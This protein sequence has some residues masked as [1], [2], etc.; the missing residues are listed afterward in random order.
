MTNGKQD[1]KGEQP[2]CL[3]LCAMRAGPQ[4]DLQLR[5]HPV[6]AQVPARLTLGTCCSAHSP[7]VVWDIL[8]QACTWN[9]PPG[10]FPWLGHGCN[11]PSRCQW[12]QQA[13]APQQPRNGE[14]LSL[15]CAVVRLGRSAGWGME[16]ISTCDIFSLTA[17]C[18]DACPHGSGVQLGPQGC[19]PSREML[20][21][22]KSQ[23]PVGVLR[24][25]GVGTCLCLS[26]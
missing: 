6:K 16:C 24:T 22:F 13:A 5:P 21:T 1:R 26:Q 12:H 15:L 8:T 3:A 2:T 7:R 11:T 14:R 9:F 10:S 20:C 4:L 23:G 19:S 17:G 18:L 25:L